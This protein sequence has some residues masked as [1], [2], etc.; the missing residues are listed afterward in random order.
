M[1][2]M[3]HPPAVFVVSFNTDTVHTAMFGTV[4][5]SEIASRRLTALYQ[6]HDPE[7]DGEGF[8]YALL[9]ECVTGEHGE[10]FTFDVLESL[11]NRALPDMKAMMSTAIRLNGMNG[12]EVAKTSPPL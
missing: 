9:C 6:E 8:G 4:T 1:N 3:A 2:D 7:H 5:V 12:E 10:R 11:P